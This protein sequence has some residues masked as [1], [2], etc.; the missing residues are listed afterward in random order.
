MI[1]SIICPCF[2][3]PDLV[4]QGLSSIKEQM[5]VYTRD[6]WEVVVV[7]DGIE[8]GTKEICEEFKKDIPVKYLFSGQ[9]NHKEL[10]Y[11]CPS[12][13]I[14]IGVRNSHPKVRL[15]LL[16]SPE[17]HYLTPNC[18][19]DMI[20]L[21]LQNKNKRSLITPELGYDD[22]K[23][24][25][26]KKILE[27]IKINPELEPITELNIKYPFC[28]MMHKWEFTS[29]GGYDEDFT[30]YCYDDADLIE[31]LC[32][33]GCG[34]YVYAKDQKI[35]HLFHGTRGN[36]DGLKNRMQAYNYNQKLYNERQG[37]PQRNIGR[38]W[39]VINMAERKEEFV[40]TYEKN[41][42]K[43]RVS[44][45][46]KGSDIENVQVLI[47]KM[48]NFINSHKIKSMV[49]APCGDF[50]WMPYLLKNCNISEYRG[51][52]IVPQMIEDNKKKY[53][54]VHFE[55]KDMVLDGNFGKADML[56]CRDCLVHL[57]HKSVK[58]FLKNFFYDSDIKFLVATTFPNH[59]HN[60]DFQDGTNW[61]PQNLTKAPFFLPEPR[62]YINEGY[63]G[64]NGE[65]T[66]KSLGVWTKQELINV[67]F[68]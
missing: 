53:P 41:R 27:G 22:Q 3:R 36:R 20:A 49:D 46:G 5:K 16:T 61:Y 45:S 17:I 25:V 65:F 63:T 10:I 18:L 40:D 67:D 11:R 60:S 68:K 66:D 51:Y 38:E 15:L 57:S 62:I 48:A 6:Q 39:G 37:I 42:F 64:D 21:A 56:F 12:F 13:A 19:S 4:E 1:L 28:L 24:I 59:E 55:V 58:M 31:R 47:A 9:R 33:A 2:K 35:I 26:S 54:G 52:D 30:G 8:D 32:T 23:G 14:N 29:I 7:N 34:S 44:K 43:G 50:N